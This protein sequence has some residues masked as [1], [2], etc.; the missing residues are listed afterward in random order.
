[1][2]DIDEAYIAEKFSVASRAVAALSFATGHPTAA[3]VP[4]SVAN[5][6]KTCVA[7]TIGLDNYSFDKADEY[8]KALA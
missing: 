4:H 5:A 2:L 6:F 3:S 8:K 7:I 1:M